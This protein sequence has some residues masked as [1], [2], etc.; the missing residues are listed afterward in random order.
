MVEGSVAT[1]CREAGMRHVCPG[2]SSCSYNS[3]RCFES[4]ISTA[5]CSYFTYVSDHICG[6]TDVK[7][8]PIIDMMFLDL[9]TYGTYGFI[10]FGMAWGKNYVSG[11]G[12]VF[13]YAFCA[14]CEFCSGGSELYGT[15]EY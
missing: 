6:T 4:P 12:G 8:C 3:P 11:E 13:S 1:T 10:D 7:Q 15:L 5:G 14:I 2:S 9:F